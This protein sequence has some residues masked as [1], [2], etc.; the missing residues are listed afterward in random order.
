MSLSTDHVPEP[1]TLVI[2]GA[3]G[4][5]TRRKLVPAVF[6]LFCEG[7]L[8]EKFS[9]VGFARRDKSDEVFREEMHEGVKT[10][11]RVRPVD[12]A[13]WR[14]FAPNIYYHCSDFED[15]DGFRS[16]KTRLEEIAAGC[17][18]PCNWLFYLA[19]QPSQVPLVVDQIDKAG[20]ACVDR[21]DSCWSRII[22]EKPFGRDLESAQELNGHIQ[23]V[24]PEDRIFRIDH[25]LGKE[26]VQNILVFR[27][28]NSI[29][30]PI[31]NQKYVDHVQITVSE[32]VGVEGRGKFYEQA[33]ALRDMVQNHMMHLLSLTAMESPNSL[34][35]NAVRDEKV[36]VLRAL[37][38]IPPECAANG[39]VRAQYAAGTCGGKPVVGY[40]DEEGVAPDSGTE[41]YVAFAAH[42]DNWRWAGV[43]FYLRT[44]KRLPARITE[45][46]LHFKRVP[47]VLFNVNPDRPMEP[48]VL[49]LRIQPNE[50][51]LLQFQIKVPGVEKRVEPLKMDFGYAEAFGKEPPEAYERL[52]LDAARGDSTLFTRSDEVEAAWRFLTPV[53]EGC[54][55]RCCPHHTL[56]TY[57]AGTWGPKEAYDLIGENGRQWSLLRRPM[58]K[59]KRKITIDV[60]S[61]RKSDG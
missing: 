48:N 42:I 27:F 31:W 61:G 43:P 54:K 2:F 57:P 45:I 35:A 33:G 38:P 9:V 46:A 60:D 32:S 12:E 49:A 24:F 39:I 25:Y 50:G 5:L 21:E 34:D 59:P 51:I 16:L 22:V 7:L 37:R 8:P 44:G 6:S 53:I 1:F 17:G 56:P 47:Q 20:L 30:E 18:A 41:A 58:E 11:A 23:R 55:E 36:K 28:A 29:F 13:A 26:T 52:L 4:D 14:R 10:F 15:P 40:H 19:T 3:S